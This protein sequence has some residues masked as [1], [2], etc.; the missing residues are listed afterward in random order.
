MKSHK[1]QRSGRLVKS[2]CIMESEDD[3]DSVVQRSSFPG[4]PQLL[5]GCPIRLAPPQPRRKSPLALPG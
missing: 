3:E 4:S 5:Q 2:K 1:R